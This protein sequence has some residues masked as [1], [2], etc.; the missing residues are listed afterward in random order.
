[1]PVNAYCTYFT[2]ILQCFLLDITNFLPF[3]PTTARRKKWSA[4]A[5]IGLRQ[6]GHALRTMQLLLDTQYQ[7]F[8]ID[9][10]LNFHAWSFFLVLYFFYAIFFLFGSNRIPKPNLCV[11]RHHWGEVERTF[12][13][14][15]LSLYL[16]VN[17]LAERKV[18]VVHSMINISNVKS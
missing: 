14:E 7:G 11:Y 1:M 15:T 8:Q 17:K 13:E 10:Q 16:F 6:Q 18:T 5:R 2:G 9:S 4:S 12:T 3:I